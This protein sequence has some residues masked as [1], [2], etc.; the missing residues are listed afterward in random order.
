[1]KRNPGAGNTGQHDDPGLILQNPCYC[2]GLEGLS[3]RPASLAENGDLQV[4]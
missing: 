1:M 2:W 3:G 4:L